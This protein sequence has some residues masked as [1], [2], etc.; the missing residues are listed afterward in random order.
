MDALS[1]TL[2]VETMLKWAAEGLLLTRNQCLYLLQSGL[3]IRHSHLLHSR[4]FS[5]VA[6]SSICCSWLE[7]L[8]LAEFCSQLKSLKNPVFLHFL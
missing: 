2:I 4:P 6:L 1:T 7:L 5:N 3:K 8:N